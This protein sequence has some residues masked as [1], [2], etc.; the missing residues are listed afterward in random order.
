MTA[1]AA[2]G[3]GLIC[4]PAPAKINLS[5]RVLGRRA[6]GY[7]ELESLVAFTVFGDSL[8]LEPAPSFSLAVSGPFASALAGENLIA[9]AASRLHALQPA[10]CFGHVQLEKNIPVAAG[11]GGGSADAAAFLRLVRRA[12]ADRA[13]DL[14]W[15]S[16][17]KDLGAD[18]P[19]CLAGR[20]A[21]MRG[22]GERIE[23]VA[24][25]PNLPVVLVNP[26]QP[27][28]TA[29]VFSRL[30]AA[31]IS[32]AQDAQTSPL[33]F[34]STDELIGYLT[35]RGNDLEPAAT[36]LCPAI[37]EIK[38]ALA[39]MPG[40]LLARMSGSGP[41]C[42]GL[43]ERLDQ[44]DAATDIIQRNQPGWWAIATAITA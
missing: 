34:T 9:T 2:G 18:V 29:T 16:V 6:D 24:A 40:V 17:A 37:A 32:P 4:E 36:A 44:A 8:R 22:I 26:R 5:L 13:G 23:P 1:P 19:V 14:D 35:A 42:F 43:F 31:P 30:R 38:A 7:H 11:I 33:S 12:N 15:P 28:A 41:T 39:N 3:A 27:L 25:I 10:L 20:P 21:V